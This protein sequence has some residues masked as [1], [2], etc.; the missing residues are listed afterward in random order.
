MTLLTLFGGAGV[1]SSPVLVSAG[2]GQ[3][4]A[5]GFAPTVA[6]TNHRRV[7][8]G[9]AVVTAAGLTP[10]VTASNHQR[11]TAGVGALSAT[12]LVPTI[13]VSAHQR[14]AAGL[15][16]LSATGQAPTVTASDHRVVVAGLGAVTAEGFAPLAGIGVNAQTGT[17]AVAAE[18]QAPSVTASL[19]VVV[20]PDVGSV[21]AV[22]FAPLAEASDVGGP[23]VVAPAA[24]E[25][26]ALGYAPDVAG[27]VVVPPANEPQYGA[28]LVGYL[29]APRRGVAPLTVD[30]EEIV[31]DVPDFGRR[32]EDTGRDAA[33]G[34]L[35]GAG[36]VAEGS[37]LRSDDSADVGREN[38]NRGGRSIADSGTGE[39]QPV[40]AEALAPLT[41]AEVNAI[42]AASDDDDV[43]ALLAAAL[44]YAMPDG[45]GMT[46]IVVES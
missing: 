35:L 23:V 13:A 33:G 17:G 27:D 5:T 30:A 12:G 3:M 2:L 11:V 40:A 6:V 14:V 1:T 21:E 31:D 18:G 43:L 37:T 36:V 29:G 10:L 46:L 7:S 38:G 28:L 19:H 4:T 9:V 45:R 16:A 26:V 41:P 44:P 24:G 15:G 32:D 22:G 20:A 39:S 34:A 8:A 42:L 25:L